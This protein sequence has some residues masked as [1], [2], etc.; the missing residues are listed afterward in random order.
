MR[1]RAKLDGVPLTND[2]AFDAWWHDFLY[3]FGQLNRYGIA[4]SLSQVHIDL[5]RQC[6]RSAWFA[7]LRASAKLVCGACDAGVGV[8][9]DDDGDFYHI[10][11]GRNLKPTRTTST[12]RS[13]K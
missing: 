8:T 9:P 13:Q 5:M 11:T 6:A 1:V 2:E 7:C 12:A 3:R 4:S 10:G